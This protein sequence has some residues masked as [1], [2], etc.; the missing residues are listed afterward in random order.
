MLAVVCLLALGIG[1]GGAAVRRI[2]A[3]RSSAAASAAFRRRAQ[4]WQVPFSSGGSFG[5]GDRGEL[6]DTAQALPLARH[7]GARRATRRAALDRLCSATG[8]S[9]TR[10][11][12]PCASRP[13]LPPRLPSGATRGAC[14]NSPESVILRLRD[15]AVLGGSA[16]DTGGSATGA[17]TVCL[18][19]GAPH[20]GSSRIVRSHRQSRRTRRTGGT[21]VDRPRHAPAARRGF[22]DRARG[23]AVDCRTRSAARA[24]RRAGATGARGGLPT[25]R[26]APKRPPLLQRHTPAVRRLKRP[27][28]ARGACKRAVLLWKAGMVE[29]GDA[30]ENNKGRRPEAKRQ[31]QTTG[32]CGGGAYGQQHGT[33]SRNF[34]KWKDL[35]RLIL[36]QIIDRELAARLGSGHHG[37]SARSKACRTPETL[38]AKGPAG[39]VEMRASCM[40]HR[41]DARVRRRCRDHPLPPPGPEFGR[42]VGSALSSAAPTCSATMQKMFT[43]MPIADQRAGRDTDWVMDTTVRSSNR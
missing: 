29:V 22:E 25:A 3:G 42:L 39:R 17:A 4:G 1:G 37:Q 26:A 30:A 31:S 33:D 12:L 14:A 10:Q 35:R 32:A 24:F 8:S 6:G 2:A 18:L 36:A 23:F 43:G 7:D 15:H 16:W 34:Q 9:E 21:S 41:E 5:G 27:D 28:C 13:A 20:R 19:A 11:N 40:T 38:D